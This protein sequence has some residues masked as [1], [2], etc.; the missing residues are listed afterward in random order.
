MSTLVTYI[1]TRH[2]VSPHTGGEQIPLSLKLKRKDKSRK[3]ER[4]IQRSNSG[5]AYIVYKYGSETWRC[6]TPPLAFTDAEDM[7]EFLSS[8]EDQ[9]FSF[10][11]FDSRGT[12]QV[13]LVSRSTEQ[14]RQAGTGESTDYFSFTFTVEAVT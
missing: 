11:P 14:R 1:A 7:R 5:K 8:A 13:I 2:L 4:Q 6:Q 9:I 3:V 12:R 10:D